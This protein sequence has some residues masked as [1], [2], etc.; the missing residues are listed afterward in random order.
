MGMQKRNMGFTNG[1]HDSA[2][3]QPQNWFDP[4]AYSPEVTLQY[5]Y[6]ISLW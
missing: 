6:D 1:S 3:T 4:L 5:D 2:H